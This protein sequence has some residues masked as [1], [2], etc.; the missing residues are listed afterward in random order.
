M[1]KKKLNRL[2]TINTILGIV[3]VLSLAVNI[4]LYTKIGSNN[5]NLA[6]L[7]DL[8]I[9]TVS[10]EEIYPMFLCPCCGKSIGVE[11][12]GMAI[13][14]KKYVDSLIKEGGSKDEVILAYVKKYGFDSFIDKD[15][16]EE[17]KEELIKTAPA[18]RP[19]I[20]LN[21][22]YY[23]FGQI[24]ASQGDVSTTF[25]V[26]NDGKS[27]LIITGMETSCGC[28]TAR[29]VID[30]QRS[31]V[32]SM[33]NN[34]QNWQVSLKPNQQATLEVFF[35][36]NFHKG[37]EGSITRTIKIF[38]NDPIESGLKVEIEGEIII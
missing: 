13:E 24:E 26:E 30:N 34:P 21:P 29:L 25:S 3:L 38:S 5:K 33:H 4:W 8:S 23:D 20:S 28:T 14:R 1:N 22:T 31:P 11:C 6:S 16:Q 9:K 18:N 15:R 36:P 19:I 35:D 10:A 17:Y 12:C 2:E 27:D 37:A 7:T 32:F